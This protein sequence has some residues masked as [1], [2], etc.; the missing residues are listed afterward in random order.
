MCNGEIVDR[1]STFVNPEIPIPFRIETLTHINDQMVMNAPKIEEILPKFLEF[2]EDAVMV[3]HNAE[4]D[5]SFIINKAEKIG[6]NVDTTIIDTVLLAQ[7]LMPNLHN[8]KLD[9]LTKHLNVVLE[10]HHR[11]VDDAAATADI[12]VKM[13]KMLYD[14]DIPDVDKLN[15]EGKMDENASRS[16][17]SITV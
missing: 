15:E 11:A 14:R 6:I 10:S 16:F 8:Y 5:T 12:F 7:F 4:F 9:T 13:I 2:C 17:I 3:A 1:F